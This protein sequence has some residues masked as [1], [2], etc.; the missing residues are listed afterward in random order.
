MILWVFFILISILYFLIVPLI[1]SK[2]PAPDECLPGPRSLPMIGNLF[3]VGIGKSHEKLMELSEHHGPIYKLRFLNENCVVVT[4]LPLIMEASVEKG[5]HFSGRP[6]TFRVE[7]IVE[8]VGALDFGDLD[9]IGRIWRNISSRSVRPN[10]KAMTELEPVSTELCLELLDSWSSSSGTAK[11][12][13][14]DLVR[15][16]SCLMLRFMV[17]D[18]GGPKSSS[19]DM[20][21]QLE[22]VFSKSLDFNISGILLDTY[23]WLRY[24]GN[25]SWKKMEE[26]F[27]MA[28]NFFDLHKKIVIENNKKCIL[29]MLLSDASKA[30][31][32]DEDTFVK[33]ILVSLTLGALAT[34]HTLIHTIIGVLAHHPHIQKAV[35]DEV[36]GAVGY[37]MPT[38]TDR[39]NM[40]YTE[41]MI[42]DVM[43]NTRVLPLTGSHKATRD[44]TLGGYHIPAGVTVLLSLWSIHHDPHFWQ[45]PYAFKP[46]RFL[47]PEGHLVTIDHPNRRQILPFG[48]G[49]RSCPGEAFARGRLFLFIA[50]FCQRLTVTPEGHPDPATMDPRRYNVQGLI[51]SPPLQKYILEKRR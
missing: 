32:S 41:A 20:L 15:F 23:P 21:L 18:Y 17:E 35:Q 24:F 51:L 10:G 30:N 25:S 28:D 37:R 40:P 9:D 36:D 38:I 50:M 49:P 19:V 11:Y 8:V 33:G 47:D 22:N 48:A 45:D 4:S 13:N 1:A 46:E 12:L 44:T 16:T 6:S 31:V 5:S 27:K 26:S 39:K 2:N 43:R 7:R 29:Q 14:D 3:D 42:L 34:T